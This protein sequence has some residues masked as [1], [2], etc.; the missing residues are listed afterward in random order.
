[1]P[2]LLGFLSPEHSWATQTSAGDFLK[3]IITISANASQNE[4]SCIGPNELTRQLVS[5]PCVEKL[6]YDMLKGGNPLTVGVGIVIEVI[7][8]NNSDYDPDVGSESNMQPSSRDPIYLGTLLRMFA[9][10][11]PDFMELILSPNHTVGGG[12]GPVTIKRRELDAAFGGKIEP[13]GFDRFKTCELMAELLHC[14]NMGLLNEPGSEEFVKARDAERERLKLEGKLGVSADNLDSGNEDLTMRS[15][16]TGRLGSTSPDEMRRLEVQ[17]ASDD[18]GFEEVTHADDAKDD[19]DEKP[20]MDED[21]L[22][23]KPDSSLSFLDKDDEE[24]VDEPLSSPRLNTDL[25]PVHLE[26]TIVQTEEVT[27][28]LALAPLPLSPSKELAGHLDDLDIA[29]EVAAATPLPEENAEVDVT[30]PDEQ[31]N[32]ALDEAIEGQAQTQEDEPMHDAPPPNLEIP[33]I[34]PPQDGNFSPHPDD[35]PAP[36]FSKK[37]PATEDSTCS[38]PV[39]GE[40]GIPDLRSPEPEDTAMGDATELANSVIIGHATDQSKTSIPDAPVVG[41]YLKMQFVEH[42]VVPTILVSVFEAVR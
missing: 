42:K 25:D 14:S 37:A 12:D 35:R 10:H 11:V 8:K 3:A 34:L 22:R 16:T 24:F 28:D 33:S 18:D 1:M 17:N 21:I 6:I 19:F 30:S 27:E 2:I 20:D 41:D 26:E 7:R 38:P 15:S 4:Q 39:L 9:K 29:Q 32:K 40:S 5:Q 13:L 36:L 23:P 31:I